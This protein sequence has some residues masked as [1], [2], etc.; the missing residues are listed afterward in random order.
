MKFKLL[1][2]FFFFAFN[3]YSTN[4]I[5]FPGAEG[6]G[7]YTTGGRGGKVV[8]V[9]NINDSGEGSLRYALNEV[10]GIRTILFSIAGTIIL[11]TDLKV[12]E[13]NFTLAG[14]SA[15]GMGICIAGYG[16]DI[17]AD[18]IV[19]R[20]IRFR[21]GDIKHDETDAL[22]VK[23]STNVIIDHCS[24]SWSTDETCSCYDN[25]NFTLQWCI[26]SE[27]LNNSA[28][29]KGEHGYGGIWGGKKATFH[30]N[31]LAHHISRNPRL[32]GSRYH[33]QPELE[34][35]EIINNVVY[36]W[37]MKCVYGGEGGTYAL[38]QNYFKAGPAT[39][40]KS[41]RAI[42]EPYEPISAYY[43]QNN[44]I[45]GKQALTKNNH[46]SIKQKDDKTPVFLTEYPFQISDYKIE[47]ATEA[48]SKV[49]SEAGVSQHRDTVDLRIIQ[50]VKNGTFTYGNFGIINS[51][52]QV[53][54]WPDLSS[55]QTIH[56]SDQDGMADSWETL[57]NLNPSESSDGPAYTIQKNFTNLEVYLNSLCNK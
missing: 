34:K 29:H 28:H 13:G 24:M 46:L 4:P 5:A 7:K 17:E 48:Y 47:L 8:Y 39:G 22:T 54:N 1:F 18:N 30:H 15:P 36:N 52:E 3:A 23:R 53:G 42:L 9:T 33:K 32:Q 12:E 20:Y 49:L 41:S 51:Q 25:T 57:H 37:E 31:L 27:S 45:E 35:A 21:P 38:S 55:K 40:K 16:L 50:E 6:C 11:E 10:K 56:D 26:I 19:I 44:I 43:F 14:Q 2:L